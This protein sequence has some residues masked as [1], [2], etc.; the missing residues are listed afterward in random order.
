MLFDTNKSNLRKGQNAS[1]FTESCEQDPKLKNL[2]FCREKHSISDVSNKLFLEQEEDRW[3]LM[4][5]QE[6]NPI[7]SYFNYFLFPSATGKSFLYT[8]TPLFI[9]PT[10]HA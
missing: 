10:F 6:A 7:L 3:P 9:I 5:T 1:I 8:F 4:V 2:R